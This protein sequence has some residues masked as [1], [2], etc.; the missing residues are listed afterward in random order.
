MVD[1]VAPID[2]ATDATDAALDAMIAGCVPTGA[3]ICGDGIDQDCSGEDQACEVNDRPDGAIDITAGGTFTA[4]LLHARDDLANTG[5]NLD[6]GNDVFYQIDLAAPEVYYFDTFTSP[7]DTSLRVFP[8][9]PCTAVTGAIEAVCDNDECESLQSQ[10]A[11]PLPVGTSCVVVDKNYNN[12]Q[13]SDLGAF[14]LHVVRGGRTGTA[15]PRGMNTLTGDTCTG[16]NTS[17][18]PAGVCE[19]VQNAKDLAFFFL[20]CPNTPAVVDA[21]TC[22]NVNNTH[23]DTELYIS[24]VGG[25]SLACANDSASCKVRPDRPKDPP[26]GSVLTAVT[27]TEPGLHWLVVDG[28][29]AAC[30]RYQLD[31]NYR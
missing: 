12:G 27:T 7:F 30:G 26:D 21:S 28:Y 1:A 4:D 11:T 18:P 16:Q 20:A 2:A 13:D 29:S 22:V 17:E 23:F 31:T 8:G 6:G 14:Q 5:C 24:S 9:T 15:L 25:Q 10:L 19:G 3:E